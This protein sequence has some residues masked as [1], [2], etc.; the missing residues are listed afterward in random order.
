MGKNGQ[1]FDLQVEVVGERGQQL[2][3]RELKGSHR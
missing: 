2:R 3:E 1:L